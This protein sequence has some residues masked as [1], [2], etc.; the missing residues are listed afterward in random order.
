MLPS[1][2]QLLDQLTLQGQLNSIVDPA[3]LIANHPW[4]R[5]IAV[6]GVEM[7][8]HYGWKW[9]KR[10]EPDIPQVKLELVDIWHF[11]L[12]HI[13]QKSGGDP[14]WAL[15]SL[16]G[17]LRVREDCAYIG[18]T[19][20]KLSELET[21]PLME[22]LVSLAAGGIVSVTAFDLLREEMG[23]SWDELHRTYVAKSALN[24]FRQQN[25]YK[26]GT[27]TKVW[28]GKEDNEVLQG[29][30]DARPDA[31][32]DQLFTKL[33]QIYSSLQKETA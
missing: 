9:W 12:S 4:A 13:L 1:D 8:D 5:A 16:K 23:L 3:W 27:Y 30:L 26:D 31:T 18:Y 29:L 28:H 10:H 32:M 11:I 2:K 15:Q 24:I 25:G 19:T 20:C 21:L 17:W 14:T 7:M 22:A 33:T 6:E